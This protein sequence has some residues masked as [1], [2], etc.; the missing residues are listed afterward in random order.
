MKGVIKADTISILPARA[1]TAPGQAGNPIA[2]ASEVALAETLKAEIARLQAKLEESQRQAE[3]GEKR[4][5]EC[6]LKLGI[7]QGRKSAQ[8]HHDAMLQE[9]RGA[10]EKALAGFEKSLDRQ[11]RELAVRMTRTA[12]ANIL[13]DNSRYASLIADTTAH[14][15]REVVR[16]SL[17]RIEVSAADFP[18]QDELRR[19]LAEHVRDPACTIIAKPELESG[20]CFVGLTLGTMDIGI[21]AQHAKLSSALNRLQDADHA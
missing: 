20:A 2:I 19:L 15:L 6:G 13:G 9:L 10:M 1:A 3:I 17:I 16:D 14:H 12:L 11:A 8:D 21:Q 18:D 5:Q 7:E 4:G